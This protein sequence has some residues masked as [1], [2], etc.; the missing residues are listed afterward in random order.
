MP[1]LK[2]IAG[3]PM[4][5]VFAAPSCYGASTKPAVVCW[6][7]KAA[8]KWCALGDAAWL[9]R[10]FC[11]E[12][13]GEDRELTPWEQR[14]W[15]TPRFSATQAEN[16]LS[17][18]DPAVPYATRMEYVKTIAAVKVLYPQELRRKTADGKVTLGGVLAR[19]V[20][21]RNIEYFANGAR[22]R[23]IC[24]VHRERMATGTV[25]NEGEHADMK[26]WAQNIFAQTRERAL[27]VLS[28]WEISKILRHEASFYSPAPAQWEYSGGEWLSRVLQ[29]VV[30]P[31]T[32]LPAEASTKR[33]GD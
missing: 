14:W 21:W 1:A 31:G 16:F 7:R 24:E 15:E 8:E 3:D 30:R 5:L 23:V 2:C 28:A 9:R 19:A 11:R 26:A 17:N 22:W 4:H 29:K 32:S 13:S 10:S 20:Q 12:A 18:L 6:L 33:A 25:G 27:V